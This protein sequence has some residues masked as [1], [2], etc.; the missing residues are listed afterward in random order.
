MSGIATAVVAGAVV[1]AGA[2]YMSSSAQQEAAAT[3]SGS[4]MQ[5]TAMSVAEQHRQFDEIQKLFKPYIDAG[6]GALTSQ[7]DLIGING[8][9][10]QQSATNALLGS[11]QFNSLVNQ[12]ENAI[13]QNASAT[14]GLRGGNVQ[15]ALAQ[16]RPQILSQMIESQFGKLGSISGM[17]QAS[18]AG[19]ANLGQATGNNISALY[20]QQGQAL[21]GQALASGQ[22]QAN[23]WGNIGS[24]VS[25]GIG[26]LGALKLMGKF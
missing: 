10:K 14:G 15:A 23:L 24:S 13:L 20:G 5:S 12:G 16:F 3:A 18:A 9:D 11:Y 22:A 2:A 4:Q 6:K 26:T 8:V 7:Q 25:G 1:S 17:G 19:E 21:A